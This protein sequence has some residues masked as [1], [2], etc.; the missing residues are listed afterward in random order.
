MQVKKG[1]IYR[2][3]IYEYRLAAEQYDC[4]ELMQILVQY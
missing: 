4:Y 2:N 1:P 3:I